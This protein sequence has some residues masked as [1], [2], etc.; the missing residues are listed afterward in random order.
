MELPHQF[1]A[2][3]QVRGVD[4]DLSRVWVDRRDYEAAVGIARL[5]GRML[6]N[7]ESRDLMMRARAVL[8]MADAMALASAE[9]VK[10]VFG[11]KN[12]EKL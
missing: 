1:L 12:D 5:C 6:A 9:I 8:E 7:P 11:D 10:Q 4:G 2:D 3:I